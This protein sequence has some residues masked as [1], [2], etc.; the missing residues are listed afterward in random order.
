MPARR[1]SLIT[2]RRATIRPD[3]SGR[4]AAARGGEGGAAVG[5]GRADAAADE[6]RS[7]QL[8]LDSLWA[9][10]ETGEGPPSRRCGSACGRAA[11]LR[12][13]GKPAGWRMAR[14]TLEKMVV[15]AELERLPAEVQAAAAAAPGRPVAQPDRQAG[16]TTLVLLDLPSLQDAPASRPQLL[17]AAAGDEGWRAA[18]LSAS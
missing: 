5:G 18:A 3:C 13:A 6:G 2:I 7:R 17:V 12:I 10:R 16:A 4:R 14:L 11:V 15:A 9:G 8:R 1:R